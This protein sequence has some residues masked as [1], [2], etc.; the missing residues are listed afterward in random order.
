MSLPIKFSTGY[1]PGIL[2]KLLKTEF[3]EKLRPSCSLQPWPWRF[4]RPKLTVRQISIFSTSVVGKF[5]QISTVFSQPTT[6]EVARSNQT[7]FPHLLAF[8]E[9][10]ILTPTNFTFSLGGSYINHIS[11]RQADFDHLFIKNY[12]LFIKSFNNVN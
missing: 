11:T 12:H 1:F 10:K 6:L 4:G 2:P 5:R 9:Y 8:F 7:V 3:K